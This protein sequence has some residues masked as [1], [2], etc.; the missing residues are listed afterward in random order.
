MTRDYYVAGESM[1][2]VKGNPQAG[3]GLIQNLTQ[4]G[5]SDGPIPLSF[6]F[7]HEDINVDA[8]GGKNVAAEVQTMLSEINIRMTLMHWDR[9]VLAAC[10][11]ESMGGTG[12]EGTLVRAGTRLGGAVGGGPGNARFAVGNHFLGLNIQCPVANSNFPG[13]GHWRFYF[14]YLS[15]SPLEFPLGTEKSAIQLNWRVIPYTRDPWGGLDAGTAV[16]TG[17]QGY[18]LFDHQLDT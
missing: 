9:S 10:V 5:L 12:V 4:L 6:Q 18:V 8:W 3:G 17:A 15:Q 11:E 1:V 14:A 2:S 7:K 13:F 16:G